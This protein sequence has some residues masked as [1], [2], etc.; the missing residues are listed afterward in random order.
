MKLK[1]KKGLYL[2][3]FISALFLLIACKKAEKDIADDLKTI[4]DTEI[5]DEA[6]TEKDEVGEIPNTISYTVVSGGRT[7][8][9]DAKVYADGYGDVPTFSVTE[10]EDKDEFVLKYAKK[11]FDKGEFEN[12][13][14][15]EI[16]S[17]EELE[18]EL[19]FYEERYSENDKNSSNRYLEAIEWTIENFDDSKNVDYPD[20]DIVY[21]VKD[22]QVFTSIQDGTEEICRCTRI[23]EASRLR[24]CVDGRLWIMNYRGSYEDTVMQGEKDHFE[25]IPYLNA[26]CI[27]ENPLVI[28]TWGMDE[29]DINN[30]CDRESAEGYV[31]QFL[32]KLGMDNM[33]LLHIMHNE[34]QLTEKTSSIDGYT[35]IFGMSENG[36]HLLF[37]YDAM[38]TNMQPTNVQNIFA[39]QPYVE[40]QVNGQGVYSLTIR[41]NYNEPEIMSEETAMLSFE[42]VNEIAEVE[43]QEHVTPDIGM[44]EFG[45]VYITYDGIS[46]AIVP[47][48]RYYEVG[49]ERNTTVK[50]P[51][52][53]ICALDGSVIYNDNLGV[54]VP[55]VGNFQY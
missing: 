52:V 43:M 9:V 34:I 33:E 17:R 40:I 42:Q 18:K 38:E 10:Y 14:P 32:S 35:M 50:K 1:L 3:S 41:G 5:T 51:A 16:L 55:Y 46:Y 21:T 20:N 7:S 44:I 22:E 6:V 24:G 31:R 2:F 36:A 13:K 8:K 26:Y 29:S 11:L 49:S 23:Y 28:N 45:Y 39:A 4:T 15:D 37:A 54:Y 47:V 12:I 53:T 19:Q 25:K 48:W 27:D 30:L